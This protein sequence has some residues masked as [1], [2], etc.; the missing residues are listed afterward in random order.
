M[1]GKES[2]TRRAGC[3][4]LPA[5]ARSAQSGSH[6]GHTGLVTT[7]RRAWSAHSRPTEAAQ[8]R[9]CH[10]WIVWFRRRGRVA[11]H[12]RRRRLQLP[13][14]TSPAVPTQHASSPSQQAGR[15]ARKETGAG[16]RASSAGRPV[17]RRFPR[18]RRASAR[19]VV[20][21]ERRGAF[22]R[23]SRILCREQLHQG[24]SPLLSD[25]TRPGTAV[26]GG[27]S[28]AEC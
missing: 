12:G 18:R 1:S 6:T 25:S 24:A 20:R 14:V 11:G 28:A 2:F 23:A 7:S 26:P 5:H 15:S 16:A 4:P 21:D 27:E 22:R 8:R 3:Q 9:I 17:A 10:K 19:V 13:D